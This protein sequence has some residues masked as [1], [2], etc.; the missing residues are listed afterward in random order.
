VVTKKIGRSRPGIEA[1]GREEAIADH[2]FPDQQPG[3]EE[4]PLA[5]D[6]QQRHEFTMIEILM[7]CKRLPAG[8]AT[9][10]DGIPNEVLL[11]VSLLRPQVLLNTLNACLARR[12]FPARWK[13][14]RLVLLHKGPG[15]PIDEPSSFR[16]LCMLDS[17]GKLLERLVLGRLNQHLDETGQRSENQYGFRNGRSTVDAIERVLQS[18]QGAATGADQHR[19]ISV[20]VSLDVKNAFNTTPWRKTDVALRESHIPPI[21]EQLHTI[22]FGRQK[23]PGRPVAAQQERHVWRPPGLGSR[24]SPVKRILRQTA[25]H[26]DAVGRPT[27]G[28]CR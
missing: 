9:G 28:I 25:G 8:K 4:P 27:S 22:V 7:A 17:A 6:E 11:H 26:G 15:K 2:L 5:D 24:T 21:S 10:P 18:A 12:E 23:T 1:R 3:S 19:D 13:T 16:P 14:A 20:A